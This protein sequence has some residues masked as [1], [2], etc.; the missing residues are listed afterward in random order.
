MQPVLSGTPLKRPGA[1]R[2]KISK[3]LATPSWVDRF[4]EQKLVKLYRQR[5]N[6]NKITSQTWSVDHMVPL[7]SPLVC[8]LHWHSNLELMPRDVN[9]DK[10]NSYW[11]DMPCYTEKDLLELY[12]ASKK[13]GLQIWKWE[14]LKYARKKRRW[15]DG[16]GDDSKMR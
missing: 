3:M 7:N 1:Q 6:L 13:L 4:H 9:N 12:R 2:Y 10:G 16:Y 8:G 5:K 11:P 14:F 15:F